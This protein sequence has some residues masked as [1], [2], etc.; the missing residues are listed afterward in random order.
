MSS[1][2]VQEWAKDKPDVESDVKN[3]SIDSIDTDV[4]SDEKQN[5]INGEKR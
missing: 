4:T 5:Q 3:K 2:A 1:G